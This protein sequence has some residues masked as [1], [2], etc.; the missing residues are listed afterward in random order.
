M[1]VAEADVEAIEI[2]TD[3]DSDLDAETEAC[4]PRTPPYSMQSQS[5][6]ATWLRPRFLAR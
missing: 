6:T 5:A 3:F 4:Q 1:S 2:D